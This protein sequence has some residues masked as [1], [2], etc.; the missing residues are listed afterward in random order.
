MAKSMHALWKESNRI[1]RKRKH[2]IVTNSP[3]EE[4]F[5][6]LIFALTLCHLV[7]LQAALLHHLIPLFLEGD[8]DESHKDIDEEEG[9][10][11]KV[12]D[13]ENGH[14]HPVA[15][16]GSSVLFSHIHR[17]LQDPEKTQTPH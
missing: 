11:H 5:F 8:D 17:V 9:K 12:N 6:V 15:V 16:T 4:F 2:E 1:I 10:N 13:V 3:K 7:L 14:F